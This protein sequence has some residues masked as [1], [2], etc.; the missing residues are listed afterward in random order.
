[1][2]YRCFFLLSSF[3]IDFYVDVMR[4]I[5]WLLNLSRWAHYLIHHTGLLPDNQTDKITDNQSMQNL[6]ESTT[7]KQEKSTERLSIESFNGRSLWSVLA[8]VS[9]LTERIQPRRVVRGWRELLQSWRRVDMVTH[10]QCFTL[11]RTRSTVHPVTRHGTR[12]S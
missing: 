9:S 11:D 3:L 10:G 4:W 12:A 1:M 6:Q 8:S 7:A 5:T 2:S